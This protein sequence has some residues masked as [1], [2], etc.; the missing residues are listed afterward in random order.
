MRRRR[1]ALLLL[2]ASIYMYLTLFNGQ[3][4]QHQ[5]K[6]KTKVL[7]FAT[8]R[9]GS[10]FIGE[11]FQQNPDVFYMFEPLK[12]FTVN[13]SGYKLV[14]KSGPTYL[15]NYFKCSFRDM[16]ANSWHINGKGFGVQLMQWQKRIFCG[17]L[18]KRS[19]FRLSWSDLERKCKS[20]PIIAVKE[21]SLAMLSSVMALLRKGVKVLHLIR[22]PRGILSSMKEILNLKGETDITVH[23]SSLC[24][25]LRKQIKTWKRFVKENYSG[26]KLIRYEDVALSTLAETNKIYDFIGLRVPKQVKEWIL[27]ST[28]L[29]RPLSSNQKNVGLLQSSF[30][31]HRNARSVSSHWRYRLTWT[32]VILI[33]RKCGD[34]LK[35]LGYK[36]YDNAYDMLTDKEP[37]LS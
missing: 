22:D 23:I 9:S 27:R 34:V 5:S 14:Q 8:Y 1:L 28:T 11:L 31:T 20:S 3:R 12:I 26:Y 17:N 16:L 29:K 4:K 2:L 36:L 35:H 25:R 19:C 7:I 33:Q 18:G 24:V 21:I 37:V 30:S 6:L 10:S 15:Q 13:S 32:E